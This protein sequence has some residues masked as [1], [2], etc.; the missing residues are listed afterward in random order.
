MACMALIS[1]SHIVAFFEDETKL[2]SRGE[3]AYKSGRIEKFSF[4]GGSG[5]VRGMVRSSLKDVVYTVEV[6][7]L[8]IGLLR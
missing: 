2:I 7:L 5:I 8:L 3:N 4:D 6:G 1:I